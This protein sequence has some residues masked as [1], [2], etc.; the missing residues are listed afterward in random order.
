M[1]PWLAGDPDAPFPPVEHALVRPDG[2]LAAGGDLS[3]ERLVRAYRNG[4]FPWYSAGQPIL[5]WS[6]DPRCVLDTDAVYV[7]RRTARRLRTGGF[8]ITMDQAFD[9]VIESCAEPRSYEEETWI[10]REMMAAYKALRRDG[11][12]HSLEVWHDGTL[13]GGIYGVAIGRMF[14]GESMFHRRTDASKIAL[15][16]LCRQ[17]AAWDFPLLDCQMYSPHLARMGARLVPRK[18][19]TH[20]IAR[21]TARP[22]VPEPWRYDAATA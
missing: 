15:V 21:L 1:I 9:A 20:R 7:S 6:P 18:W 10:T 19:F 16:A 14:F 3:V 8:T 22:G 12:A 2:L 5:W 17:L 11:W 13:A 4:I